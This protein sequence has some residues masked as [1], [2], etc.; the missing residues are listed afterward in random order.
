MVSR[1]EPLHESVPNPAGLSPLPSHL[2]LFGL[3]ANVMDELL[4][5]L[6]CRA[7]PLRPGIRAER[8]VPG[9]SQEKWI[10]NR[11]RDPGVPQSILP[12]TELKLTPAFSIQ[13]SPTP[14]ITIMGKACL[15]D[16]N[17][18]SSP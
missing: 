8:L 4:H 3:V 15:E 10:P 14:E 13:V 2:V 7:S 16:A 9:I 6:G 1:R 11:G 12:S 17:S 5:S 18:N